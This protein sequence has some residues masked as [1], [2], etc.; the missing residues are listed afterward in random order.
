M[1]QYNIREN[2]QIPLLALFCFPPSS[3]HI[4]FLNKIIVKYVHIRML[5]DTCM[6]IGENVRVYA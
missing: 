1:I 5:K 6:C 2:L 4:N 3:T